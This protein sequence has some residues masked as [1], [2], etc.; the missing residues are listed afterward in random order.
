MPETAPQDKEM[1]KNE[2]C[3][4][5]DR[6]TGII[7]TGLGGKTSICLL[8]YSDIQCMCRNH[9][10]TQLLPFSVFY[11]FFFNISPFTESRYFLLEIVSQRILVV[12]TALWLAAQHHWCIHSHYHVHGHQTLSGK[13]LI[14]SEWCKKSEID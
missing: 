7:M 6:N 14:S 12:S 9:C 10:D 11:T 13:I 1:C 3:R 2:G 5:G 4:S 8:L